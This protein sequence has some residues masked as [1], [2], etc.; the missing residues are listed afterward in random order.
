MN[1]IT[2]YQSERPT[3]GVIYAGLLNH[4][5]TLYKAIAERPAEPKQTRD[6]SAKQHYT[7]EIESFMRLPDEFLEGKQGREVFAVSEI[8]TY[9]G[10]SSNHISRNCPKQYFAAKGRNNL[11]FRGLLWF[12]WSLCYCFVPCGVIAAASQHSTLKKVGNC[13]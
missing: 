2:Q 8:A 7:S 3:V 6:T 1:G 10:L 4:T 5:A 9:L 11:F 13:G 12:G